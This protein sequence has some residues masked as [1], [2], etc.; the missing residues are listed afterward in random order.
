[1][2]RTYEDMLRVSDGFE[3]AGNKKIA[4]EDLGVSSRMVD[5]V[6]YFGEDYLLGGDGNL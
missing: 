1:M 2:L 3:C 6:R 5:N 4:R